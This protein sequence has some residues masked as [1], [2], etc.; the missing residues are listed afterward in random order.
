MQILASQD[1]QPVRKEGVPDRRE[2]LFMTKLVWF[3][4]LHGKSGF[5]DG[6]HGSK[7][8]PSPPLTPRKADS[9]VV[10]RGAKDGNMYTRAISEFGFSPRDP[11]S[12]G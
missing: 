1:V 10:G 8:R 11:R 6:S 12:S 4:L 7:T 3:S 9:C 2:G 5:L